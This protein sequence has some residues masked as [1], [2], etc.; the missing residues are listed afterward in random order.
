MRINNHQGVKTH[1]ENFLFLNPFMVKKIER[2]RGEEYIL[3]RGLPF[4]QLNCRFVFLVH[5]NLN[6]NIPDLTL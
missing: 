2:L 3:I 4:L 1:K 6:R 5:N